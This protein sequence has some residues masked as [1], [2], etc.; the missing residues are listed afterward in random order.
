MAH[1]PD[2]DLSI[3]DLTVSARSGRVLLR[4]QSLD[5]AA[6]TRL[7]IR[8]P[9]GAGKSTLIF[10]IAGLAD[11]T[12]GTV[13]WGGTDILALPPSARGDFRRSR[14]GIV[15]QDFHLFEELSAGENAAVGALFSPPAARAGLRSRANAALAELA[16]T[17][18]AQGVS[19]MSGG[20]RQRV[21][22]A[23][24][25]A[26]D[27]GILLADEPTANLQ[28]PAADALAADLAS[29][30]RTLIVASH[31]GGVL[32]RMDRILTLSDGEITGDA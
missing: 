1:P 13:Q 21:A 19:T 15:F 12:T 29:G 3:R 24:A 6:G 20:E 25:V 23:R 31:D 18:P 16:V 14:M 2:D 26:S 11:D 5:V 4:V 32:K 7:G 30:N 10:A 17:D 28:R 8:G 27:P 9:S 22:L